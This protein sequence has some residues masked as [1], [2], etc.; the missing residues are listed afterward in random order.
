[1][2]HL[3]E[4]RYNI[5]PSNQAHFLVTEYHRKPLEYHRLRDT[6]LEDPTLSLIV[7]DAR[8]YDDITTCEVFLD[9]WKELVCT[10]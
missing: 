7:T 2:H 6:N 4:V 5:N 10:T 3:N 9:T 1:M 8:Y